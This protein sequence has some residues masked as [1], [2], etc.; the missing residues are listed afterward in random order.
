MRNALNCGEF[1][2]HY[3]SKV[4]LY[5]GQ[6]VGVEALIRWR[7]EGSVISP[8]EFIPFAEETGLIVPIGE[9]VLRTACAQI[10]TWQRAI[11][12]EISV[13]VNLTARQFNE[14]NLVNRVVQ[15]LNLKRNFLSLS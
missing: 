5:T 9:W 6:I 15:T 8:N 3:Q 10:K 2:L 4:D 13:S 7:H 14:K 11:L 12:P 1:F